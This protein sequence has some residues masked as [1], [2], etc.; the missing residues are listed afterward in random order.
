M[1]IATCTWS[2]PGRG[3]AAAGSAGN[4][5]AAKLR[6]AD[7]TRCKRRYQSRTLLRVELLVVGDA[8]A[9]QPQGEDG[10]SNNIAASLLQLS[11]GGASVF[12]SGVHGWCAMHHQTPDAPPRWR[13]MREIPRRH[14]RGITEAPCFPGRVRRDRDPRD[15]YLCTR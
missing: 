11:E 6:R 15:A 9:R 1:S 4:A 7:A 3:A 8:R 10:A 12:C 5:G 2:G 14:R 13:R